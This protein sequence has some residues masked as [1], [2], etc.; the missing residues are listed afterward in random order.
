[1]EGVRDDEKQKAKAGIGA[2]KDR[3]LQ[4]VPSPGYKY[5]PSAGRLEEY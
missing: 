4:S 1:M 3:N 2:G 5:A